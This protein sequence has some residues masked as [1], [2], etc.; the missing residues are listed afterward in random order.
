[1]FFFSHMA[2]FCKSLA[3]QFVVGI[4]FSFVLCRHGNEFWRSGWYVLRLLPS[5]FGMFI[6]SVLCSNCLNWTRWCWPN[7]LVKQRS[8]NMLGNKFCISC[9]CLPVCF[10]F[11]CGSV[12][13]MW[14][15]NSIVFVGH[16]LCFQLQILKVDMATFGFPILC[17]NF[18]VLANRWYKK[19]NGQY[20]E[21]NIFGGWFFETMLSWICLCGWAPVVESQCFFRGPPWCSQLLMLKVDMAT[22][23]HDAAQIKHPQTWAWYVEELGLS[24][25]YR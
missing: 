8:G 2:D 16:A 1:M 4:F 15:I 9:F 18:L 6:F 3:S 14:E 20:V 25:L 21:N 11:V 22:Y 23:G 10:E 19:L 7:A 5:V 13:R 17:S 12:C 24:K